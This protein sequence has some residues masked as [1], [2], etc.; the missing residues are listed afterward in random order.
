[1]GLTDR[2]LG[3]AT[4]GAE[5]RLLES[6]LPAAQERLGTAVKG[7]LERA[8]PALQ[9]HVTKGLEAGLES[10]PVQIAKVIK[11]QSNKATPY[12]VLAALGG[13]LSVH[14]G[15]QLPGYAL[16]RMT[17]QKYPERGIDEEAQSSILKSLLIPGYYGYKLGIGQGARDT[18]SD[19]KLEALPSE[20]EKQ[21]FVKHASRSKWFVPVA[22]AYAYHRRRKRRRK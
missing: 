7:G 21:G 18:L 6:I 8:G 14:G 22:A 19:R 2:L 1:M 16:G 11:A 15:A 12:R 3:P 9:A 20:Q 17:E 4:A 10:L 13:A 5:R